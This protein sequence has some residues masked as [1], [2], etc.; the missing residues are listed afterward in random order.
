[1]AVSPK[2]SVLLDGVS[3]SKK[4]MLVDLGLDLLGCVCD[5]DGG[6]GVT[7]ALLGL[8]PCKAG[9]KVK[10]SRVV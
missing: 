10:C 7:G 8:S 9:K 1:M 2:L 3:P 4:R 5:E 6:V